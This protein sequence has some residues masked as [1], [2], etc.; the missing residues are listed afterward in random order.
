MRATNVNLGASVRGPARRGALGKQA[1][2]HG[3]LVV[4]VPALAYAIARPLVDSDALG[5][6]IAGAIPIAY[7]IVL[8]LSQRRLDPIA[9]LVSI[10]FAVACVASL[11]SGGSS[12]PL[13]LHEATITFLIGLVLLL[14]ALVRRPLPLGPLLRMPGRDG[15]HDGLLSA[16]VGGFLV[17]HAMLHLALAVSLSTTSYLIAGRA[18]NLATILIGGACLIAYRKRMAA[19]AA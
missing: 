8:V 14:A 19:P 10:G 15:P 9:L 6:T 13:K 5:L 11:L 4:A 7:E 12:L 18:I 3:L 1:A 17:L 2:R 16:L